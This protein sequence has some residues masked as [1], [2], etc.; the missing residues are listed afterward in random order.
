MTSTSTEPSGSSNTNPP[1]RAQAGTGHFMLTLCRL[2]APVSIRPP[3]SPHLKP[4]TFFTSR[5]PQPDGSEWLYLHMGYFETLADAERWV[6]GIRGRY[7]TAIATLAPDAFL[8]PPNSAAPASQH[9]DSPLAGPGSSD[10]APA[11]VESLT[12]TQV[13]KILDT[14]GAS[15]VQDEVNARDCDQ[16]ALLRP[17]DTST[18]QALK[19]A[20]A[21]GAPVCFAVQLHWSA[22]P[23]D[24]SRVPSLAIFKAHTLYGIESRRE[25]RSRYFLRMGFFGDPISAKQ[26]AVQVRSNFASAA[27]VPVSEEEVTRAREAGM[28]TSSIPTLVQQRVERALDA[29]STP[30]SATESVPSSAMPRRVS[31]G[32]MTLAQTLRQLAEREMWTDPDSL[33]ESGVRHLR[34]EVQGHTSGRS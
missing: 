4:F 25:G 22:E 33:S 23:I 30:R 7:P 3:Q 17:D 26:V 6:E 21:Q 8:R 29:N 12:D 31:R 20:V 9:V 16:I 10:L 34:V 18:R 13:L 27:V 5:A 28:G 2:A 24:L 11:K 19:E 14:R 1:H 15:R 32:P